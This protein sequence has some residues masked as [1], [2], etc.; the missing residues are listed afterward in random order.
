VP[1]IRKPSLSR[2]SPVWGAL[3]AACFAFSV[4][5]LLVAGS[6]SAST[7]W[8]F[9]LPATAIASQTPPYPVVAV[10]TLTQT[11]DGVQ[12]V[13]DPNEN[14]P[15]FL[16]NSADSFVE[17]IDYVYA[18]PELSASD[19]RNDNGPIDG[20]D[21]LSNPNNMDV[22]Y[23][24]DTFHIV[25]DFPSTNDVGRFNPGETRTWT[26][27]GSTLMQFT[28][29]SASA[30]S[31]PSPASGVISVSAYDLTGINPTPPNWVN[32]VPEPSTSLLLALGLIGLAVASRRRE[33]RSRR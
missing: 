16:A 12:F 18:G 25:V 21:F 17:Q 5:G 22:G 26:V 30:N 1:S 29:T 19:F 32:A 8:T 14:S 27:L 4:F 9:E 6:A 23:T 20:F 2:R 15:G 13:L 28:G 3:A 11:V 31:R 33:P 24:A 10:L 7:M